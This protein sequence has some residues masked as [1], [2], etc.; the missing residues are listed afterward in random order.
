[1]NQLVDRHIKDVE[2]RRREEEDRNKGNTDL[3]MHMRR[4]SKEDYEFL[5]KVIITGDTDSGKSKILERFTYNSF[6]ET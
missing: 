6:G 4:N 2:E 1:M 5:F 3:G